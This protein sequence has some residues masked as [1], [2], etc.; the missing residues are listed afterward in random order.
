M[1]HSFCARS[2]GGPFRACL[3]ASNTHLGLRHSKGCDSQVD[4][5]FFA[6]PTPILIYASLA[7]ICG[8]HPLLIHSFAYSHL[9][10]QVQFFRPVSSPA[11]PIHKAN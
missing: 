9:V 7:N 5:T 11:L 10:S 2:H 6:F 4:S 8:L 1:K 3:S